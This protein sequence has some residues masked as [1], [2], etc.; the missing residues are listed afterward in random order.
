MERI[1]WIDFVK[2]IT[3]LLVVIGHVNL[4]MLLSGRFSD[5]DGFLTLINELIYSVHMPLF[6]MI[7][8][9]FYYNRSTTARQLGKSIINKLISLGIP[10]LVFS[11]VMWGMKFVMGSHIRVAAGWDDLLLIFTHPIDHLWFLYSL[12]LIFLVAEVL[13]YVFKNDIVVFFVLFAASIIGWHYKTGLYIMDVTIYM[14][15]FFYIGKIFRQNIAILE[16]RSFVLLSSLS[17]VGLQYVNLMIEDTFRGL[18]FVIT[19]SGIFM[20]L[21]LARNL[22]MNNRICRYFYNAGLITMPVFLIHPIIASAFRI[23][24]LKTGIDNFAVHYIGGI[25]VSWFLSIL[26]YKIAGRYRYS[27]FIFYPGKYLKIT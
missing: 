4:G 15:S 27:D 3:I 8:G 6:F 12:F 21:S 14:A 17:F 26:I 2:G 20:I 18:A 1:K 16:K 25:V 13:D 24:L 23:C 19:M 9:L 5:Q 11:A 10:Y 22:N 7:S